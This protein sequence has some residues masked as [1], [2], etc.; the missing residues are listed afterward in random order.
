M[1]DRQIDGKRQSAGEGICAFANIGDMRTKEN[2][3]KAS[4]PK[5]EPKKTGPKKAYPNSD[6]YGED[7]RRVYSSYD[8]ATTPAAA[9]KAQASGRQK[10]QMPERGWRLAAI[11][12]ALVVAAL[13]AIVMSASPH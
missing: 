5:T 13:V 8:E 12:L 6:R 1:A 9:T 2:R 4:L 10:R 11:A 7:G 3:A